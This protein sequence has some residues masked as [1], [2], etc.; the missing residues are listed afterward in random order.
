MKI[1]SNLKGDIMGGITT[2]VITLP[3]AIAFGI[4]AYAPLGEQ[5][6]A[7][8]ALAGLYGVIVAGTLAALFGG[9]SGLI[10]L[11]T[12]LQAV[13]TTSI[14]ATI[15]KDPEVAALGSNQITV[16]LVLTAL[17]ICFAG[18]FQFLL[19][20]SGGGKLVKFIPY[21]VVAG[22]MN[23]IAIIIFMGQLRPLFGVG[24]NAPLLTQLTGEAGFR[25]ETLIVGG[26]T[27]ATMLITQR[28]TKAIPGSLV[29]LLCG[30]AS[31]FI[32][33][34]FFNPALLEITNNPLIIGPVP[35]AIPSPTQL[36]NFF[37]V[38]DQPVKLRGPRKRRS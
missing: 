9:T 11:P 16:V 5:Y 29:G 38:F 19:G 30:V 24:K 13:M 10:S 35:A 31:Y 3:W 17:T 27:I 36:L 20:V 32:I 6:V 14:I 34:S 4:V 1:F 26:V 37:S 7:Q 25:Y 23:G 18:V 8:G 12:A 22:F 21:P 15:L 28:I 2:A 33:G